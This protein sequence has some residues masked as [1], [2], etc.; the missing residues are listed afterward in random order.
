MCFLLPNNFGGARLP[1]KNKTI[2]WN[3]LQ[4]TNKNEKKLIFDRNEIEWYEKRLYLRKNQHETVKAKRFFQ[5][6]G[7]VHKEKW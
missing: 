4:F 3:L 2:Q 1:T 5:T 7:S 6:I